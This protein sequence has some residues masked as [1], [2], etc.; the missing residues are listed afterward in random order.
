M[1]PQR[2]RALAPTRAE[3]AAAA[4]QA[5]RRALIPKNMEDTKDERLRT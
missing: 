1:E 4:L 2:R 5:D 3:L